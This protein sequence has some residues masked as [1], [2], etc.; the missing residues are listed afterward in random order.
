MSFGLDCSNCLYYKNRIFILEEMNKKLM[1]DKAEAVLAERKSTKDKII[2][3]LNDMDDEIIDIDLGYGEV[4]SPNK[5][6]SYTL[7]EAKSK[8]EE[9]V[10]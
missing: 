5:Y 7:S 1:A 10:K 4:E 2:E 6:D 3:I 9:E 8:I